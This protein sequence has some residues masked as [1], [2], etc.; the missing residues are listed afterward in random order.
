VRLALVSDTYT[1][2][3]NGVTTVLQRIEKA[4]TNAGQDIAIVAP[5]YPSWDEADREKELRVP[6]LPFPPYPA[7]RFTLPMVGRVD[8]FLTRYKP[9]IVHVAT[10]GPLGLVGRH[11]ATKAR[12]PLVTSFHTDFPRYCHHYGVPHLEKLMWRFLIWFHKAALLTQTP[13]DAIK[14]KLD[15]FGLKHVKVWGRGVDTELF[16]PTRRSS[17][18]RRARDV[19]DDTVVVLHVGRMAAEKNVE[20]LA[21]SWVMANRVLGDRALF[22]VAGEGPYAKR[23]VERVP[24][25]TSLG[26]LKQNELADVYA[27]SDICVLPSHTETCG[28]VA[29]EAMASGVPVIAADAGGFRESVRDGENGVLVPPFDAS[30]YAESIIGLAIDKDLRLC[31]SAAARELAESRDVRIEDRELLEQYRSLLNPN[32]PRAL[33]HAA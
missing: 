33:C 20:T 17:E 7:I 21:E 1:P 18:W 25:A 26:F 14:E 10:E 31:F 24:W 11:W 32:T 12:V 6:S 8:R 29:L 3:V 2:Q 28:L 13:G 15:G 5:A 22:L 27:N 4:I 23:F 16:T 19:A 9:D 30:R